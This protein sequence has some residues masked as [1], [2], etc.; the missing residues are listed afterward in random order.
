LDESI[1]EHRD[2]AKENPAVVAAMMKRVIEI[3]DT[4]HPPI[5]NPPTDLDGYW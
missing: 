1:T 2:V 4:Y 3:A 5:R